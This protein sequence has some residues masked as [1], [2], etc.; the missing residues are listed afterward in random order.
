MRES[1]ITGLGV[2]ERKRGRVFSTED[3]E[4]AE[5]RNLRPR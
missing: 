5:K 3:T 4:F 1:G 2:E